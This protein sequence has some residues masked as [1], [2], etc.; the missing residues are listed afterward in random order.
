MF[1]GLHAEGVKLSYQSFAA[2]FRIEHPQAL[3]DELQ[4]GRGV[5]KNK[6]STDVEYYPPPYPPSPPP[7]PSPPLLLL[8]LLLLQL[9]LLLLLRLLLLLLL[10]ISSSS[11]SICMRINPHGK[12]CSDLGRVLVLN[13]PSS[14]H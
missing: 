13:D 1:E 8:F 7:T 10:L 12:S 2:G 11:S 5:I 6:H 4:F 9:L 14:R 3:L